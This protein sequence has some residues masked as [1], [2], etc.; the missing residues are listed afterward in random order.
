MLHNLL[1]PPIAS[2]SSHCF[3]CSPQSFSSF[4]PSLNW[5]FLISLGTK[6]T[7]MTMAEAW[8]SFDVVGVYIPD[9]VGSR[10]TRTFLSPQTHGLS[11]SRRLSCRSTRR[12][13]RRICRFH[14]TSTASNC[15]TYMMVS[16]GTLNSET[17]LLLHRIALFEEWE[18]QTNRTPSERSR[19]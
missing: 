5:H 17:R 9:P 13:S 2:K 1:N 12:V 3:L 14:A 18:A 6:L 4:C 10:P 11:L 7:A 16:R 8:K 15:Q 19:R